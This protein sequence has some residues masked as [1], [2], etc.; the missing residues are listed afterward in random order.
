[1][2]TYSNFF[3]AGV[4]ADLGLANAFVACKIFSHK[5]LCHLVDYNAAF[6]VTY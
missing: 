2:Q 3:T 5:K 1:M 6:L 4:L